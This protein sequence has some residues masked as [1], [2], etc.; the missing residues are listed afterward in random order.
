MSC[1]EFITHLKRSTDLFKLKQPRFPI[2]NA[3]KTLWQTLHRETT[4]TTYCFKRWEEYFHLTFSTNTTLATYI[5]NWWNKRQLILTD[6]KNILT[7]RFQP[8]QRLQS[9]FMT[10]SSRVFIHIKYN[11]NNPEE[12]TFSLIPQRQRIQLKFLTDSMKSFIH[13]KQSNT[14]TQFE[15]PKQRHQHGFH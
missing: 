15:Q 7:Y 2:N 8:I 11:G 9:N 10:D 13:T 1:P 4:Q 5:Y 12:R 14:Q 6:S 3:E